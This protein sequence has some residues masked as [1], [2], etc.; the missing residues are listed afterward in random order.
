MKTRATKL[1][2]G[3]CLYSRNVEGEGI[4]DCELEAILDYI[5]TTIFKKNKGKTFIW[6]IL[7]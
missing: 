3:M 7:Y 4:S 5:Q 6:S 2:S 1:H